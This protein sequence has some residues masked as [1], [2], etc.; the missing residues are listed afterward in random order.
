MGYNNHDMMTRA[1]KL[2]KNKI[3]HFS[4][5]VALNNSFLEAK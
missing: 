1:P 3:W 2:N 4:F 5:F